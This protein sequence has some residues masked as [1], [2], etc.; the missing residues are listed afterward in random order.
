VSAKLPDFSIVIPCL[1]EEN[2]LGSLLED[3]AGQTIKPKEV[4]VADSRSDDCTVEVAKGFQ[5]RLSLKIVTST[6]RSPGAA[7]N[8]GAKQAK[9]D[10]LVFIDAD[11]RLPDTA[12]EQTLLATDYGRLDY[13]TP[14]FSTP[15]RHPIDQLAIKIINFDIRFGITAGAHL[16][17]IGGYMCVRRDLHE[18]L[19]GFRASGRGEDMDYLAHLKRLGASHT[20]LR[21]LVI[22]TSNRRLVQDGRLVSI[23]NFIPQRWHLSRHIVNPALK[24]IGKDKKFGRFN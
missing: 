22:R 11:M 12:F 1:N 6:I 21:K 18:S 4:I 23:L 15:G 10:Y 9:G 3:I 19:G 8:A 17:G 16:P 14:L 2:Y 5:K 24:K 7:R 20:V 13:V